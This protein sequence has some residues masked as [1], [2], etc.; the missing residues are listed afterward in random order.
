MPLVAPLL[1]GQKVGPSWSWEDSVD[2]TPTLSPTSK[3]G[4]T[5]LKFDPAFRVPDPTSR[6]A[7]TKFSPVLARPVTHSHW[8]S[9]SVRRWMPV[10]GLAMGATGAIVSGY[11]KTVSALK[12]SVAGLRPGKSARLRVPR[13]PSALEK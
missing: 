4:S 13:S 8:I 1:V 9:E 11:S 2:W 5:P 10:P 3:A 7:T 6:V 12:G